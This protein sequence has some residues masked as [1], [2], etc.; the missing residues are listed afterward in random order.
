MK[1]LFAV[2]GPDFYAVHRDD[3]VEVCRI[4][5]N[6]NITMKQAETYAILFAKSRQMIEDITG[7]YKVVE[8][9]KDKIGV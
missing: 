2:K 6:E 7:M 9:L 3:N 4:Y 1:K 5:S 8:I